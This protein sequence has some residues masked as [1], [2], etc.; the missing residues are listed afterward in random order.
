MQSGSRSQT[1]RSISAAAASRRRQSC[2]LPLGEEAAL[3]AFPPT[4][5]AAKASELRLDVRFQ[6]RQTYPGVGQKAVIN[7]VVPPGGANVEITVYTIASEVVKILLNSF[8]TS[9][10][11]TISW[12]GLNGSGSRVS[13]GTYPFTVKIENKVK[14]KSALSVLQ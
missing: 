10:P 4:A 3:P 9:G 13:S 5:R 6:S 2:G 12:N 14:K 7:Y 11:K 8:Q 1:S